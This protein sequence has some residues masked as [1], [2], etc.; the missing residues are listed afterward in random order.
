M[1]SPLASSS[2]GSR[3]PCSLHVPGSRSPLL[4]MLPRD[5]RAAPRARP[6][7]GF[8]S[9][10][11]APV[12]WLLCSV[13][14]RPCRALQSSPSRATR[15][16]SS[17]KSRLAP[18]SA[19]ARPP[20]CAVSVPA[21]APPSSC[22]SREQAPWCS[23]SWHPWP[24]PSLLG[25]SR[26]PSAP[27]VRCHSSELPG[28]RPVCSSNLLR[29]P[30]APRRFSQPSTSSSHN[31]ALGP[32]HEIPCMLLK[33]PAPAVPGQISLQLGPAL[34]V[35]SSLLSSPACRA[36]F[37][38]VSRA[39][40]SPELPCAR[41]DLLPPRRSAARPLVPLC[42]SP[43]PSSPSSARPWR[44]SLCSLACSRAPALAQSPRG[45]FPLPVPS[46]RP[47]LS[48][49]Q[50]LCAPSSLSDGRPRLKLPRRS[51][52]SPAHLSP[53]GARA[54]RSP[55][56]P[57]RAPS[58]LPCRAPNHGATA[59]SRELAELC[60]L[61]WRPTRCFATPVLSHGGAPILCSLFPDLAR[62][63]FLLLLC[64]RAPISH[65]HVPWCSGVV[66][67]VV[68]SPASMAISP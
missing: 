36:P 8:F 41:L 22:S 1:V 31:R 7:L 49:P 19:P 43:I 53:A 2:P 56:L 63:W 18:T 10:L 62:P 38:P 45:S 57:C 16:R 50:A 26:A 4:A 40:A 37:V 34:C 65:G 12:P 55:V 60:P 21:M 39:L 15:R 25:L 11:L 66:S 28:A 3:A 23:T 30:M 32:R 9:V 27:S 67:P 46:L 54:L 59:P 20:S 48:L 35:C 14:S 29:A 47:L 58:P 52:C 24:R 42:C 64:A 68:S 51:P 33:F 61:P 44:P 17:P 5:A 13:L 6:A